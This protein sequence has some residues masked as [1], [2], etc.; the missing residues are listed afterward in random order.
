MTSSYSPLNGRDAC[1]TAWINIPFA[2][3][4]TRTS[5]DTASPSIAAR[6]DAVSAADRAE[7]AECVGAGASATIA[8]EGT[9]AALACAT[10]AAAAAGV[11][12]FGSAAAEHA[13]ISTLS[14]ASIK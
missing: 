2:V 14:A 13:V 5:H 4:R 7:R 3:R 9:G 11:A 6:G 8:G 10:G 1:A 12:L